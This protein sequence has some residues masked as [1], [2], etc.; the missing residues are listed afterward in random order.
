MNK[1]IEA[2]DKVYETVIK[3]LKNGKKETHWMW[4]I[5]PQIEGLGNSYTARMYALNNNDISEYLSNEV[6]YARLVEVTKLLDGIDNAVDAFGPV[7]A[8]K[9]K[10]SLTLFSIVTTN[11]IFNEMLEK[12]FDDK[13]EATRS[14]LLNY[15]LE[16]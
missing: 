3:E 6:L 1:F 13:C 14:Y 16:D 10:S 8:M 5:F 12:L 7:D 15:A 9:L 2:Q 4:F 11:P